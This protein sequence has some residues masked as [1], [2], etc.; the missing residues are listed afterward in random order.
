[1][2]TELIQKIQKFYKKKNFYFLTGDLGYSVLEELREKFKK[3]FINVGICEN[4]M[5]LLS[6]G[7]SERKNTVY[8]Y[9]I[10]PFIVLRCLEILRNYLN[11]EK[12]PVRII[13]VGSGFSYGEMGPSH[14]V[15]EDVNII[16]NLK[17]FYLV[18]PGN[19]N[20]LDYIFK[21][22]LKK[23]NNPFYIRLNKHSYIEPQKYKFEKK[24]CLFLKRGSKNS[25]NVITSGIS[26]KFFFE[27][28]DNKFSYKNFNH[29]SLPELNNIKYKDLEK[30][31]LKS[32][33]LI[34]I[35]FFEPI[36]VLNHIKEFLIKYK[37]RIIVISPKKN[38]N[39]KVGNQ[40]E[41]MKQNGFSTKNIL[42]KITDLLD[43]K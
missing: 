19:L 17:N 29:I 24:G 4:N 21:L 15:N 30:N 26:Q 12:R 3:N 37:K 23:K 36:Q 42:E 13:A 40:D 10:A 5:A 43:K 14:H 18:N 34:L 32:N 16:S 33:T 11:N 41:I 1:M 8:I 27:A 2:R 38:I 35:D 7:L 25:I 31:L 9:T 6:V 20:E 28:I 22:K 39:I